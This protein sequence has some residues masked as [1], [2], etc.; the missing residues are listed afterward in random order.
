MPAKEPQKDAA[1]NAG[2]A[3]DT[4]IAKRPFFDGMAAAAHQPHASKPCRL[5]A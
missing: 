5:E 2:A 1:Q 4:D 3:A